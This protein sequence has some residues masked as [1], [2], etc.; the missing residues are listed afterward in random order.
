MNKKRSFLSP[1]CV[2]AAGIL[3]GT[4]GILV[5]KMNKFGFSSMDITAFRAYIS[6]LILLPVLLIFKREALK[7]KVKDIWVFAGTGLLSVVFFNACYFTCITMTELSVAAILL[8]TAPAFVLIMSFLVFKE[9]ITLVKIA[10]LILTFL[11]CI[12]VSG[13]FGSASL[14]TPGLLFGLGAGFGYALY[15][16]FGKIA[17]KKGYSSLTITTYTFIFASVGTIPLVKWKNFCASMAKSRESI[18]I[19]ILLVFLT[20]IAAYVLYTKGLEGMES[21]KASILANIE[22][23]T[24]ALVGIAVFGEKIK[25]ATIIGMVLVLAGCIITNVNF[26]KKKKS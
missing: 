17:I 18:P 2:L 4:M 10:C 8:Y 13:G 1:L 23:V 5:R 3:W 7:I 22:P 24:A 6:T 25:T 12:F 11:G 26:K 21:S 20:T 14:S 19:E 15:S 16:I 9:K